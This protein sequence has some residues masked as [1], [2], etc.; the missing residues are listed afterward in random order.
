MSV[1]V[2][3]TNC[4][5]S[6]PNSSMHRLLVK[7]MLSPSFCAVQPCYGN[8]ARNELPAFDGA[9]IALH[10]RFQRTEHNIVREGPFHFGAGHYLLAS[11]P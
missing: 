3:F 4:Y 1:S 10:W 9:G 6:E 8:R 2:V 11:S 7:K 5:T